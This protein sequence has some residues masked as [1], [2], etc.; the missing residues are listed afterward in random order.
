VRALQLLG[1]QLEREDLL[2]DEAVGATRVDAHFRIVLLKTIRRKIAT[3]K[4][5]RDYTN[6]HIGS[7]WIVR[8]K[9]LGWDRFTFGTT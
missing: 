3:C 2:V 6:Y 5:L 1:D 9:G 4:W 7:S 8:R